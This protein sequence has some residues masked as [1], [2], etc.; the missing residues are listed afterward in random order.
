MPFVVVN[1][2]LV[3]K[4][5]KVLKG[6]NPGQPIR[7]EKEKSRFKP[8]TQEG[9]HK[10]SYASPVDFGGGVPDHSPRNTRAPQSHPGTHGH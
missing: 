7:F 4:D 10:T 2:I 5:S 9:W 6:V 1:G 8:I 3:V